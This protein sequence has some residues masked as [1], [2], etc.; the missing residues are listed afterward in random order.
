MMRPQRHTAPQPNAA[1]GDIDSP[2]SGEQ[3]DATRRRPARWWS[4]RPRLRGDWP[5]TAILLALAAISAWFALV[6]TVQSSARLAAPPATIGLSGFYSAEENTSFS[7]RWSRPAA[8]LTLPVAAAER[9]T[10]TLRLADAPGAATPRALTI[11]IDDRQVA[12]LTPDST[13]RDYRLDYS[14]PSGGVIDAP[15]RVQLR[16]TA[17]P[18]TGDPRELGIAVAQVRWGRAAPSLPLRAALLAAQLALLGLAYAALRALRAGRKLPTSLGGRLQQA[19][20]DE[21][22]PT[23]LF[24]TLALWALPALLIDYA[25]PLTRQRGYVALVLAG[26]VVLAS[27]RAREVRFLHAAHALAAVL[28]AAWW[29]WALAPTLDALPQPYDQRA[30]Q[31]VPLVIVLFAAATAALAWLLPPER[32]RPILAADLY[33]NLAAVV[34]TAA[35]LL[36]WRGGFTTLEQTLRVSWPG[37]LLILLIMLKSVLL[38]LA[39]WR[40][41][42][43]MASE[44][45]IALATL[46][47]CAAFLWSLL[48]WRVATM[49]LSGDE[50]AY[51]A[52]ALSL[53]RDR[54]LDLNNNG[55]DPWMAARTH[56]PNDA[57]VHE[58]ADT[59]RDRFTAAAAHAPTPRHALPI[60]AGPGLRGDR[61]SVV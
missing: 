45:R 49:G 40:I 15:L 1:T 53:A 22:R 58:I 13:L 32:R 27:R 16:T 7:F 11:L 35:G 41:A 18:A 8:Q 10:I 20:G 61:K 38:G 57:W 21:Q 50:P 43:A 23:L 12:T 5:V 54:D 51:L 36:S 29:Q 3:R 25:D 26:V 47:L 2:P 59:S 34:F 19:V 4:R 56:Y 14:R 28:A 44:R 24:A 37:V 46:A 17:L 31:L 33:S 9:Y 60:V 42:P 39:L 52:A 6:P 55:Y 30:V 48:P